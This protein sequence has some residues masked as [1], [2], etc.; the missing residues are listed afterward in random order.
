MRYP[1]GRD[2]FVFARLNDAT[3]PFV[4]VGAH[5]QQVT[6]DLMRSH[7]TLFARL[8]LCVAAIVTVGCLESSGGYEESR[9]FRDALPVAADL[10][11]DVPETDQKALGE[12]AE[13]YEVTLDTTRW[14]NSA[15]LYFI[16][17][18]HVM[19]LGVPSEVSESGATWGPYRGD[20]LDPLE[21]L[22]VVER[23]D[24]TQYS[25]AISVRPKVDATA[26]WVDVMS[27]VNTPATD[28]FGAAGTV[29]LD[30]TARNSVAPNFQDTGTI[31]ATYNFREFPATNDIVFTDFVNDRGEGPYDATYHYDVDQFGAGSFEFDVDGDVDGGPLA[32]QMHIVSSWAMNG[33]GRADVTASGGDLGAANAQV[34]ECWDATYLRVFYTAAWEASEGDEP[35]LVT[36]GS[37]ESCAF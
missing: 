27:G 18:A 8:P 12:L 9:E 24:D 28:E 13:Y 17:V 37:G 3:A 21:Y 23:I 11:I 5:S 25:Y 33:A 29:L 22:L 7:I 4:A 15:T 34:T 6:E 32:E 36:E 35:W 31:E 19:A 2:A 10:Q 14:L 16:G 20:G 1:R 26:A 30:F